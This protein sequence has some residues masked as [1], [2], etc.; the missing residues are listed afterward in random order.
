[1]IFKI[2]TKYCRGDFTIYF[3]ICGPS[4]HWKV[5]VI[6]LINVYFS[7][8]YFVQ[9][10]IETYSWPLKFNWPTLWKTE[11]FILNISQHFLKNSM[12]GFISHVPRTVYYILH[13]LMCFHF[14]N[15]WV[16]YYGCEFASYYW[17]LNFFVRICK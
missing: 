1:M 14:L 13:H 5:I 12:F 10:I 15:A 7:S 4:L 11:L 6:C 2:C 9:F 3:C 16:P 17:F 8:K